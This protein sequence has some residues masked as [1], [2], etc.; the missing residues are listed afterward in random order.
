MR[1][2]SPSYGGESIHTVAIEPTLYPLS[3]LPSSN[4]SP[5]GSHL[6]VLPCLI[7]TV[8]TSENGGYVVTGNSVPVFRLLTLH[9]AL[10]IELHGM[11]LSRGPSAYSIIKN[12]FNLKGSKAKVLAAFESILTQDYNLELANPSA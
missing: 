10:K 8:Q 2:D 11:R 1:N 7:M 6:G 9:K 4:Q 5:Q 3:F 12:E